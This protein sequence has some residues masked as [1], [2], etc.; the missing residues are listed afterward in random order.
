MN[1]TQPWRSVRAYFADPTTRV[2][3]V[4]TTLLVLG[5]LV[6]RSRGYWFDTRPLW[7]DEA[8]WVQVLVDPTFG[9]S[10]L[11]PPGFM[12]VTGV[13]AHVF[14]PSEL[15]VRALAWVAGAVVTLLAP[16]LAR[17]LFGSAGA[18]LFLVGAL[19]LHPG[20]IDLA[21]E[22]KPYS[23]SL[24]LHLCLVLT[25]LRYVTTL[26][27]RD[28]ALPLLIAVVGAFFA[29]DLVFA[30]PGV[31]LVLAGAAWGRRAELGAIVAGAG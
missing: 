16:R 4:L 7:L 3:R 28:L 21:K 18:R 30:Y 14:G 1:P 27:G 12:A 6:L 9:D 20:A 15:V 31:F 25:S 10:D 17:R 2:E 29:Q 24:A 5:G 8:T 23:V 19:A 13:L 26:R 11:R 22:F